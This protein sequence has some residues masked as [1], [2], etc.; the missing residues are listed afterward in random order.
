MNKTALYLA[1]IL[2]F[3][4]L[5][6][7]LLW[8]LPTTFVPFSSIEMYSTS[9]LAALLLVSPYQCFRVW[10]P[11]LFVMLLIDGLLIANLMYFRTYYTAIPLNSYLLGGNLADFKASVYDSLRLVDILFPL[12]TLAAWLIYRHTKNL[13]WKKKHL[14]PI[15]LTSV[16]LLFGV[17]TWIKGGFKQAY[18][19]TRQ[20]AYLC[21]S[22]P[23][24]YSIFGSMTYDYLDST[25]EMTP[26]IRQS[27]E[28][29]LTERP[30]YQPLSDK[31]EGRKNLLIIFAE[32][33]ESWVFEQTVDGQE[34]TPCINRLLQDSTTLY[35]PHVL[36]QVKG[37]RSIDAQ[38][39]VCAGLLPIKS[40]PYSSQY[41]EHTYFTL[42]KAMKP[43]RSHL[44]TID[45]LSTWNQGPIAQSFGTDTLISYLDFELEEA[46]GT[47]KR[48]GDAAFLRQCAEKM[49]NEEIWKSGEDV[50]MQF[51]TYSGHAPFRLPEE[52]KKIFFT[53]GKYP[54]K[55]VDYMTTAHYTDE[56]IG[57]FVDYLKTKSAY[58]ETLVVIVGD[59]EGLA[60]YREELCTDPAIKGLVSDKQFTPFI[61]LNSPVGGRYDEVMGQIDI[62]PT[63]LNL[64]KL[65]DY[66]WKGLGQSILHP[67]KKGFAISPQMEVEGDGYNT[68]ELEHAR[69]AYDISDLIIR[70]DYLKDY[71]R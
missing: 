22:C 25:Q 61:V 37:G 6:F 39:M 16:L 45:K 8:C 59:H 11:Q 19:Q 49:G 67:D 55:A 62:Y 9:L 50:Y 57:C 28:K 26:E 1:G 3:K 34:I 7:N 35:A 2:L 48:T 10:K 46:F 14:Y 17:T 52:L 33:L 64:M 29:W 23:A 12:S 13:V 71:S 70:F 18:D 21:S 69:Q 68:D 4:F 63:I 32:S 31:I 43:A 38:L 65:D 30:V 20:N 36:T 41:P 56:A 60:D 47:H 53:E 54:Q 40:G 24:F 44:L 66:P 42:Q 27:I 51:I 5:Y 15:L 58:K